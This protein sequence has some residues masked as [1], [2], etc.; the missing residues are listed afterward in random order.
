MTRTLAAHTA[1]T[2]LLLCLVAAPTAV[3]QAPD[4][5]VMFIE[6]T[7]KYDYD[8]VPNMPLVDDVVTFHGHVRYWG[9]ATSPELLD[10]PYA[11]K[12][13]GEIVATGT[14]GTAAQPWEP[15]R[16]P[17]DFDYTGYP[18]PNSD[19]AL[20]NPDNW[21]KN[22]WAYDEDNPPTGWRL[23]RLTWVWQPG[24]HTV[25]L[26]LDPDNT[27][28]EE[29]EVN[30]SITDYTDALLASFW[31]EERAWKY[32]HQYQRMLGIGS[33]SW[34]NWIQRQMAKQNE[35][36]ETAIWE[37]SPNGVLDRVR[38][39]RIIVVPDE[40]LPVNGGTPTNRPDSSDKTIDLQWGFPG[41]QVDGT[42]YSNHTS[43]DLNNPF[44]IEKSLIHELGHARYLIDCYGFDVHNTAHN[45]GYDSVQIM[46]GDVYV[47][48]SHYM[49]Y[50][51]F[52]E[53]LY[54]NQS[55]GV[56]TGPYD[57]QWS[58]YEAGALNRIAGQRAV[59]GN[60]NAPCNI[61]EYLQD[62][63]QNNHMQFVDEYG[64]PRINADVRIYNAESGPGWYGKT[65]DDIPDQ[66]FTTDADGYI[67]MPRNPFNPG[68]NITHTH[69]LANSV[70]IFRV[71]QGDDVWY[72]FFE[73]SELNLAY[74]AGYTQDAYYTMAIE[75]P[76]GDGDGDGLPDT[77]EQAYFQTL[78]HDGATDNEPDGL[79]NLEEYHNRAD[80]TDADTDDDGI[81]DGT[82]VH[83]Y[84]SDPADA[85]SDDDGLEDGDEI[86]LGT[87]P[88]DP[89][90]DGDDVLDGEDNCPAVHNP[91]QEDADGDGIGD[92]CEVRPTIEDVTVLDATALDVVYSEPVEPASAETASNYAIDGGVSVLAAVLNGDG[93]T[94][95][96]ATSPMTLH[97]TYVLTVNGVRD[98][99]INP[100]EILPDTQVVFRYG[101]WVRVSDGLL[102]LYP[103]DETDGTTVHDLSGVGTPMDLTLEDPQNATW[104]GGGL[105][106]TTHS[107]GTRA[108][109]DGAAT[110]IID[111]CMATNE[112]TIEAWLIPASTI[113]GDFG[114]IVTLSN[115]T[116]QRN[117]TLGHGDEFGGPAS[118]YT[119]RLR[120]TFTSSN[121]LPPVTTPEDTVTR[122][123]THVVFTRSAD[124]GRR[125]HVD[126][127]E[128]TSDPRGGDFSNWATGHAFA[129]GNEANIYPDRPWFGEFRLV[130]VYDR[131]LDPTEIMANFMTGAD[132]GF[133]PPACPG[134][135]NCDGTISWR[136]IDFF[137][138]AQNDNESAW[139]ALFAPATPTC[140]FENNDANGDGGVNWRDIDP[141]VSL[142]NTT[143]P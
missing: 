114:R 72:R 85:D 27:I 63:P 60:M 86:D 107:D 52:G 2:T 129:L 46:E 77:W 56:M 102:V 131:A 122:H 7:P 25:E 124:G 100:N 130:A 32:F 104:T 49:P 120:T 5:D 103:F 76:N 89:D 18:N 58:P 12:I 3:A 69:G 80:P 82:E 75:G 33:N 59:C 136:D 10:V 141:F 47:G 54:Y 133:G 44:F 61:G 35:L 132:P 70:L 39:D 121:G 95:T 101:D 29:S 74:W 109:S 20:R 126:G 83:T 96:L 113:D 116:S 19:S 99:D 110:K 81:E 117:F 26:V 40:Q 17:F 22:P 97:T 134:D 41:N 111:A 115:G 92:V 34:E 38:I 51:A 112:L 64:W 43:T 106:F 11:W 48:G 123:L 94:V 78:A 118:Q 142:Q 79:T 88:T 21:P 16:P 140:P 91:L 87:D 135:S 50:I 125:I 90:S 31:V 53:V 23:V 37:N 73:A 139:A 65:F 68:G 42:F 98:I 119:V 24:R 13:D 36:Y 4:L 62:L 127:E 9:N 67:Q 128:L 137:V 45:D 71:A 57:F 66:Y 14:I 143:C 55:G 15:L 30:N 84:G 8:D 93:V 6:R 138:A 105:Q 28:P 108:V 1:L